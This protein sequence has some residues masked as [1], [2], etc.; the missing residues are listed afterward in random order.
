[1][2]LYLPILFLKAH[3]PHLVIALANSSTLR[4]QT[5]DLPGVAYSI[6]LAYL[7]LENEIAAREYL[8]KA[9]TK[10]PWVTSRLWQALDLDSAKLPGTLWGKLPPEESPVYAIVMEIYVERARDL[11]GTPEATRILMETASSIHNIPTT[12]NI[13]PVLDVKGDDDVVEGVPVNIARHVLLS[14]IPAV[15]TL[16]PLGWKNRI[17]TGYDPL[18][19][20]DDIEE[21]DMLSGIAGLDAP[22]DF[23]ATA[24]GIGRGDQQEGAGIAGSMWELLRSLLP[25]NPAPPENGQGD[26]AG[27]MRAP[28]NDNGRYVPDWSLLTRLLGPQ[29]TERLREIIA[30]REQDMRRRDAEGNAG[31]G[32]GTQPP[33]GEE[34]GEGQQFLTEVVRNLLLEE[35][36]RESVGQGLDSGEIQGGEEETG[37]NDRGEDEWERWPEGNE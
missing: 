26:G 5:K 34:D 37:D 8:A 25:W 28:G 10:F 24:A 4:P 13:K 2:L 22:L 7:Q 11:W 32:T 3:Q 27:A 30:V 35:L 18:P 14:D 23:S 17:T 21:Y 12:K 9:I 33:T 31:Q 16:L 15:T 36:R 29:A 20:R 19:P 1:M 6:A